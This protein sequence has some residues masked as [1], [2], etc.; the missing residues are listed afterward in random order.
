MLL[1]RGF[2][3]AAAKQYREGNMPGFIHLSLGQE[4]CAVGACLALKKEDYITST[5]RGHGHCL[6]K[7]ADPK[8]VIK[9]LANQLTNKI[10]HNPSLKIKE[11]G[12]IHGEE[13]LKV[14]DSI[15]LPM[16]FYCLDLN[17][18]DVL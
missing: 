18:K 17:R 12:T 11:A 10:I 2:E 16:F 14:I 15:F 9:K 3:T 13:L 5:H 4:A 6:A 1:I 7:G 8:A